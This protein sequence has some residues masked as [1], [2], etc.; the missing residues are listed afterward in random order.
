[1]HASEL[2]NFRFEVAEAFAVRRNRRKAE[3]AN[4]AVSGWTAFGGRVAEA[5]VRDE[6]SVASV[7]R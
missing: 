2:A 7:E 4:L 1:V 6:P 3:L 5:D